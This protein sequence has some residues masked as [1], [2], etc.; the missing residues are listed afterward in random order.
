MLPLF[1]KSGFLT[2]KI[3]YTAP[4]TVLLI[5]YLFSSYFFSLGQLSL[6]I[7]INN[8]RCNYL[9]LHIKI[10]DV[11][12]SICAHRSDSLLSISL[13]APASHCAWKLSPHLC[14]QTEVGLKLLSKENSS[15]V[16]TDILHEL[17][18]NEDCLLDNVTL[19][20]SIYFCYL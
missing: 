20:L 3:A 8:W 4:T 12:L 18:Y 13:F 14:A 7:C 19:R 10:L 11:W 16:C 5:F 6:L 9:W 1:W 2:Q 17:Y 15:V